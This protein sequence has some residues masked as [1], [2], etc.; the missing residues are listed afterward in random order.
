MPCSLVPVDPLRHQPLV[1]E[2]LIR[3]GAAFDPGE[4]LCEGDLFGRGQAVQRCRRCELGLWMMFRGV[5]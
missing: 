4:T 3:H 5:V 2:T 1:A